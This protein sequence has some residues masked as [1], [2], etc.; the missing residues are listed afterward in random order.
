MSG[1][2]SSQKRALGG[3]RLWIVPDKVTMRTDCIF[4][5]AS[6]TKVVATGTVLGICVDDG[7]LRFDMPIRQTLPELSGSGIDPITI[8]HS[9][10]HTSGF[11][12]AK[13]CE[14]AQGDP[15]RPLGFRIRGLASHRFVPYCHFKHDEPF[16]CSPVIGK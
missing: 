2:V 15:S 8:V 4:D 14:R 13:Y 10:T 7:R 9:A 3:H 12:N 6:V 5:L 16:T 11:G 1:Y